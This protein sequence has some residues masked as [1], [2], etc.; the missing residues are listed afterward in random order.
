MKNKLFRRAAEVVKDFVRV[1]VDDRLSLYSA[2]AAFFVIISS[3]PFVSL[4]LSSLGLVFPEIEPE[5][6]FSANMSEEFSSAVKL[7]LDE[8][9]H[10]GGVPLLSFSAVTALWSASRGITALRAGIGCIYRSRPGKN[11]LS[12]R[13]ISLGFTVLFI[14]FFVLLTTVMLFGDALLK[15]LGSIPSSFI[16]KLRSPFFVVILSLFFTLLYSF[17]AQRSDKVEHAPIFHLPGAVFSAVGWLVFS[18]FYSLYIRHFPSDAFLYGGIAALCLIMLWLYFCLI[19][20]LV[21]A[22]MN[23][24]WFAGK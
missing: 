21:G 15:R 13:L 12:N 4:I 5:F 2:Q 18:A 19:L 6:L 7:V 11:Y 22:E 8:I 3:L 17:V 24:L 20:L 1:A 23:R 9:T 16:Y 10:T 14:L